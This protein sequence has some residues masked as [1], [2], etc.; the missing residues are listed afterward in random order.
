[1]SFYK[2]QR[3]ETIMLPLVAI[4]GDVSEVT[5]ITAKM[6]LRL[7]PFTE[8]SFNVEAREDGWI[9]TI[10]AATSQNIPVGLYAADA[11]L[12]LGGGTVVITEPAQ[13]KI[14]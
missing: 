5:T 10:P 6:Q 1:M 3:G 7:A 12:T 9:F 11:K 2:F 14:V 8:Y 4:D 13:V